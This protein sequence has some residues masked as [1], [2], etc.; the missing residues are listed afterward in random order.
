MARFLAGLP[1]EESSEFHKLTAYRS[2][3]FHKKKMDEFWEKVEK[4]N[5]ANIIPWRSQHI[6]PHFNRGTVFYPLS[7]GDFINMYIFFP[8]AQRYLMISREPAGKIP[9]LLNLKE[10]QLA[11]GL[12]SIRNCIWSIA[13]VNYFVTKA[14]RTEMQNKYLGGTLPIYLI[15]AARL[16]LIIDKIEP[17]GISKQGILC[18][19]SSDGTLKGEM[20]AIVGNRIYFRS[21]HRKA[22]SE[23]VYLSMYITPDL[24]E[25]HTPVGVYL[26]SFQHLNVILKSAIYLLHRPS[27]EQ[28][29]RTLLERT[30]ILIEDDSGI[31]FRYINP[32]VFTIKLFGFF[33]TPV[34]LKEIPNPPQQPDLAE[35][36]KMTSNPLPFSFGYGVLR[37]DRQSHVILAIRKR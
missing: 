22:Q 13:S 32:S 31:P 29:A 37:K 7:G 5:I 27:Y 28:L 19:I 9:D 8:N 33:D 6:E 16:G 26:S 21:P 3:Q 18:T 11:H 10:A 25:P 20:P 2:Y 23:L 15:F 17:I 36:M 14:M 35:A 1:I 34:R 12:E 4:G 30:H 24:L